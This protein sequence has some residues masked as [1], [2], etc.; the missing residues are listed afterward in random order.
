MMMKTQLTLV[1]LG[2][3]LLGMTQGFAQQT[4]YRWVDD[5]GLVHFSDRV[6]PAYANQ[7]LEI[8]NAQGVA[9]G[10]VEAPATE[11]ELAERVRL[12]AL[13]ET[14]ADAAREQAEHDRVLLATYLSVAEIV[15]LRDQR[16]ELLEAQSNVTEQYL[17][18]LTQRLGE[19]QQ[20]AASFKPYSEDPDA[21]TIPDNLE[22]DITRT[23]ASIELYE[24]TLHQSRSQQQSLTETFARDI[25]RFKELTGS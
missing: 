5:E 3:L 8:L 25:Q 2:S 17:S 20:N 16:L 24:E 12:A 23:T 15:R 9:V 13:A 10:H 14:E 19:L 11:E 1:A 18:N 22:L 7:E 21:P 4:L 6:P